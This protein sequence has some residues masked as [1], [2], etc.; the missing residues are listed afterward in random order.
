MTEALYQSGGAAD[1]P[2]KGLLFFGGKL[3]SSFIHQSTKQVSI[4]VKER[5]TWGSRIGIY[6]TPTAEIHNNG[7]FETD[8]QGHIWFTAYGHN[9]EQAVRVYRSQSPMAIDFDTPIVVS[10]VSNIYYPTLFWLNGRM[11]LIC[12]IEANSGGNDG[13]ALEWT[14]SDDYGQTWA[15]WTRLFN[16]DSAMRMYFK[17]AV[18]DGEILL[19]IKHGHPS[20]M[21]DASR[22]GF[23]MRYNGAWRVAAGNAY[24]L[25]TDKTTCDRMFDATSTDGGM[26]WTE[27]PMKDSQGRYYN[28]CAT[29][30]YPTGATSNSIY[31]CRFEDGAWVQTDITSQM[32]SGYDTGGSVRPEDE[33]AAWCF[34]NVNSVR[35]LARIWSDDAGATWQN[36]IL[37]TGE[38]SR[39]R[40]ST[41]LV[42]G[43]PHNECCLYQDLTRNNNIDW[44]SDLYALVPPA[45]PVRCISN[46]RWRPALT[47]ATLH[48]RAYGVWT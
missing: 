39:Q 40:S 20:E 21:V 18:V 36:E 2:D 16:N 1:G 30:L 42:Y 27:Q 38:L 47:T 15:S 28:L 26:G 37:T 5:D 25:P 22:H 23:F 43:L 7:T 31:L 24:A 14:Y 41:D 34:V 12:T 9:E 6:T 19:G 45:T 3:Y 11:H 48:S 44:T 13:R 32:P 46:G 29:V 10:Q 35:Q 33:Y 8:D 17:A 4:I